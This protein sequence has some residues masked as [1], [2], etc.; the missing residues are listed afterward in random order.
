MANFLRQVW[1]M[2]ERNKSKIPK[3]FSLGDRAPFG[4]PAV[5]PRVNNEA[6]PAKIE[7][8]LALIKAA[9]IVPLNK[10]LVLREFEF[11]SGQRSFLAYLEGMTDRDTISL[12]ILQ[13][14][15]ILAQD[16]AEKQG[17]YTLDEVDKRLLPG[18]QTKH[19]TTMSETTGEVLAGNCVLFLDG[20]EGAL[21]IEAKGWEHRTMST[22]QT[23]QVVRGPQEG[24]VE[25][26]RVNTSAIRRHLKTSTLV[27]ELFSVGARSRMDVALMYL[28]DVAQPK[29]VAEVKRRISA[30]GDRID[31][32]SDSG[33][34]EQL[35][36]DHPRALV[37][38]VIATERPDRCAAFLNEG[39]VVVLV[40]TSPYALIIPATFTIFLHTPEDYYLRWPFG[41]FA[42]VFRFLAA[43]V[44]LLLPAFY[45]AIVNYHQEMIPT[46]L[47]L[48]IAA[49]RENVPFPAIL[50]VVIMEGSF[51]LIRE[52][53]VRIP[54][55]IGPTIGIVGALILGQ[56]AVCASIV[57]PLL[58]IIVAI[59][60][61]SSFVIPN[62]TAAFTLRVLRFVFIF[63]ASVL[64]FYGVAFGLMAFSI[65]LVSLKSFGVPFMSPIAPYRPGNL[66][67]IGRPS[68][69]KQKYRPWYLRPLDA[70]R[71]RRIRLWSP[72]TG[73][74]STD[75]NQEREGEN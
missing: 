2:I 69:F 63:L 70:V 52:A 9:F 42:R 35:I 56:A 7:A 43:F 74:S 49:A 66:D 19:L 48:A 71:S 64:G 26:L 40:A 53:G 6:V 65:H 15:M 45:V 29:L 38:Q 8:C 54:T 13:P 11:G 14:L 37:P 39:H 28:H 1:R 60:A 16:S 10:D 41:T 50:E 68:L 73:G 12:G 5:K 30:I 24:L 3:S 75:D 61:L 23:E 44:A 25:S 59:T 72:E 32:I 47:L 17:G 58:I 20:S 46:D 34:L 4:P 21:S 27:T 36:E 18:I 51:E 57:S 55:V 62:Y 31:F 67:R 22:P 33:S